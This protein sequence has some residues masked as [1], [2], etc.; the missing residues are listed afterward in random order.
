[1]GNYE[2]S[3]KTITLDV[4]THAAIIG[5]KRGKDTILDVIDR[6]LDDHIGLDDSITGLESAMEDLEM[7]FYKLVFSLREVK[8]LMENGINK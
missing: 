3:R 1:M 5:L 6:M 4:P 2:V 8:E 7:E